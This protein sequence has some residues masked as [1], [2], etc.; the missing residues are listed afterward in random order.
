[1]NKNDKKPE[2]D[3][4]GFGLIDEETLCNIVRI[5]A[6]CFEATNIKDTNFSI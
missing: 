5:L 4:E 6:P 2:I 3:I 1:M